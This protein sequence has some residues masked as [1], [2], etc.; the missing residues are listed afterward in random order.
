MQRSDG[1]R[2]TRLRAAIPDRC[3]AAV[4]GVQPALRTR[5]DR[6]T[7]HVRILEMNGDSYRL[8][9]SKRRQRAARVADLPDNPSEA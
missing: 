4:R 1:D 5:L 6:L 2:R 9:Q 3:R 7:H 8:R